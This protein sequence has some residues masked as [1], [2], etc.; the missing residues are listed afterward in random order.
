MGIMVEIVSTGNQEIDINLGGGI[1][2]PSLML[3]EGEHGTGKSA[4]A[5]QF[6]RGMLNFDMKVLCITENTV[7]DY[8]KKM[9][10]ITFNFSEEFLKN[11]LSLLS[12][13]VNGTGWSKQKALQLLPL[14]NKYIK[15]QSQKFECVV[16]DSLS[17]ITSYSDMDNV[18]DFVTS[19]KYLVSNGMS[20]IL[21]MHP[22]SIPPEVGL[23]LKAACDV[24]ISLRS[25][26]IGYQPVKIMSNIKMIGASSTPEPSFAFSVDPIF[27]LKIVPI[28]LSE[29]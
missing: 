9:K 19:C 3:I 18:L 28:S 22:N 21:T 15:E 26:Q 12:L 17:F 16:I 4:V 20:V 14:I 13:H 24:Y 2:V 8:I 11:D 1:P 10:S 23:R 6:I 25:A 29:V 5:A 27:G 7:S